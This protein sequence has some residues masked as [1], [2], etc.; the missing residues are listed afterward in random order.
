MTASPKTDATAVNLARANPPSR[1]QR[2]TID[3]STIPHPP[4]RV[5]FLG[6]ILG[7]SIR[8]PVQDSMRMGRALGPIFT[9]RV[10]GR[11]IVFVASAAISGELADDTR[12]AKHVGVGLEQLRPLAGDG[13]FT[14]Y[15]AEPNWQRAHNILMP[16]FTQSAMHGYHPTMLGVA[17]ELVASWDR[18]AAQHA[19]VDI[20]GDMTKLTLETI[21]RTGFG[22]EFGSFERD[23][24]HPFVTAMVGT[25]RFAQQETFL[26]PFMAKL[27]R[28]S[29]ARNK[30]DIE[31]MSAEVDRVVQARRSSGQTSDADLLGLMLQAADP[32][33]GER[34]DEVNIRNQ[35][36][37]FLIAGHET[38]S[39]A[40]GFALYYL[41]KNPAALARARAEVDEVWGPDRDAD[42]T[43]QQV[44]KLRYVRRV[45]DE[46]LRLWPTAPG[47]AR[48]AQ[49]E[50]L[51]DGKYRVRKGEWV[52]VLLPM[53]HRDPA[54]WDDPEAF[55]PDRFLP[56]NVRAR[57]GHAF[58]PFGTGERAC[59]GRQFAI[60]EAML[61]LGML[62]HRYNFHDTEKYDLRVTELLTIK[63]DG[64][65]MTV[66]PR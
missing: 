15:N 39:G 47:Y 59:I 56:E 64:F 53:L 18:S 43:Y 37:T 40:L 34:L 8:T 44:T 27:R 42:P 52:L 57:P 46:S 25:L 49:E 41:L 48:E 22:Y 17:R 31:Y 51:L 4:R 7:V 9:R 13:L 12:F 60:H 2:T 26:L 50:T 45:L 58:K 20:V 36:I 61:V 65:T 16:A 28:R 14:A 33:T 3:T 32:Q 5:P 62:L 23:E 10:L 24:V 19:P 1:P 38:T 21:G 54:V 66:S 6:D 11:D 63:P 55:E 30:R 29:I 35:I